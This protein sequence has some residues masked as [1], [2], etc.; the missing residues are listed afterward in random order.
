MTSRG[1]PPLVSDERILDAALASF[2][3]VGYAAM[4]VRALNAELGLSHE[5]V[6]KRFGPKDRLFLA[7]V[8]HGANRFIADYDRELSLAAPSADLGM[9]RATLRAFMVAVSRH[10]ALG[11]LLHHGSIDEDRRSMIIE[12]T[13]LADRI[14]DAAQL[15]DRLHR[16]GTIGRTGVRDLWFLAQGAA[17]PV[18]FRSLAAMFDLFD[19]PLDVEHHIDRMVDT[20]I[21]GVRSPG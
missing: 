17:A 3:A 12:Q 14:S 18:H 1:R 19:G 16:A 8:Q 13:G 7:A 21:R 6:T 5:T 4:S 10:H 15:L 2:A 20:I 11:E 9:L